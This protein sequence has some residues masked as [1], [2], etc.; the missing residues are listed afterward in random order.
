MEIIMF[1]TFLAGNLIV[2]LIC[3]YSYGKQTE[4]RRGM[5]LGV[6]IPATCIRHPEVQKICCKYEKTWKLFHRVNLAAGCLLCGI[7]F[8][9]FGVFMLL[10][11]IW[12]GEYIAGLFYLLLV[13]HRKMYRLKIKMGWVDEKSRKI[14]RIDTAVSAASE[15]MAPGWK[16][17][18][19]VLILTA[20]TAWPLHLADCRYGASLAESWPFWLLYGTSFGI[21]LLFLAFHVA[22]LRQRN[23]VYSDHTEINLAVN[24]L[25]KRSWCQGLLSAAWISTAAWVYLIVCYDR[26]GPEL[27]DIHLG[28]YS[29]LLTAAA[30]SL[31]IPV[32]LTE[33]KKK[34]L[35]AADPAPHYIDD[36]EYW[37]SGWYHNPNDRHILVQDRFCSLNYSFNFGR[38][39]VKILIGFVTAAT[40]AVLIWVAVLLVRLETA[41]VV[42]HQEGSS[43]SVEAAGYECTFTMDD[44]LSVSLLEDL[45]D[46]RYTRTNG[47]STEKFNIGY[48]RG[49]ETGK[50]MMFLYNGFQP[51]LVVQLKDTTVF[52]NSDQEEIIYT[53]YETMK[54]AVP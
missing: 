6:H 26:H 13:P 19:P 8:F 29:L 52:I 36:D 1:I 43:Y 39:A 15:K 51:I 18:I 31:L 20:V 3:Q 14:V 33:G 22:V 11:M 2:V 7:C 54:Q 34:T 23:K 47:A 32:L 17:Q 42:L 48:F 16:W 21:N 27:A 28:M 46:E 40:A 50:C 4:Y 9:S 53:W 45:P 30:A 37:K 10:W 35:L 12:L 44:I 49:S 5:L 24:R 38:P 25:T 41:E